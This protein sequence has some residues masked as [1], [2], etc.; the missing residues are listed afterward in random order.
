MRVSMLLALST[1]LLAGCNGTLTLFGIDGF[2]DDDDDDNPNLDFSVYDGTEWL[3]IDWSDEEEEN[4]A[5]DCRAEWTAEGTET[6]EADQDLCPVCD[7]IWTITLEF[8]QAPPDTPDRDCL[9]Q[10]TGVTPPDS[11][12]RRFGLRFLSG[13]SF[14]HYRNEFRAANPLGESPGDDL[15]RVGPGEFIGNEFTWSGFNDDRISSPDGRYEFYFSG[16][17]AF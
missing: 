11:Y 5:V 2:S 1:L 4:G 9:A 17:G 3:N 6:T 15:V 7:H 8:E 14:V 16:S 13:N 12:T 10:G